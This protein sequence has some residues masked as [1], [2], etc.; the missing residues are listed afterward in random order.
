MN[1]D[2]RRLCSSNANPFELGVF[3]I[4]DE[5]Y[6]EVSNFEIVEHLA[7]LVLSYF[8]NGF[9][10]NDDFLMRNQVRHIFADVDRFVLNVVFGLLS[11]RN[12]SQS[13][14]DYEGILINLLMQAMPDL[15]EYVKRAVD[16]RMSLL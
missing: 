4:D 5:T 11:I 7:A 9:S 10:I 14:F 15:V 13:E 1:A 16:D 2:E 3:E 12:T 8:F 6:F